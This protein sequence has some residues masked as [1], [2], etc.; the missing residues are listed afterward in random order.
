MQRLKAANLKLKVSKCQWF[1]QSLKYLGHIVSKDG[2]ACDPEKTDA[3]QPW[4]VPS[5][6]THV[7]QF[8]GFASYYR[9]FIPIFSE[10]A[11]PLT[12]LTKKSI[13][14]N[15]SLDCQKAFDTLKEQLASPP[16]LAYLK[17]EGEYIL[18]TDASNHAM[19][20]VL[21]Q[22]QAGEERVIS[23]ASR[24]LCGEQQNYCTTKRE[25]LAV[26]NFVEHFRYFL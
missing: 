7:R 12:R 24:A 20:A 25:L 14:F 10:I 26:V 5:T 21:S 6:V 17:D 4:P 2:I 8:I 23:F 15:W 22:I 19:G 1:R 18:D 16:V 13:R 11:Q 9:K 3:I